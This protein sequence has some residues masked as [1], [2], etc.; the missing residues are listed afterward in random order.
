[1]KLIDRNG[2]Y[3]CNLYMH[4]HTFLC[5]KVLILPENADYLQ[6]NADMQ[7]EKLRASWYIKVYCLKL[8]MC[9]YSPTKY[10]LFSIVLTSFRQ[11]KR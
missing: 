6:K 1:M 3:I 10:Q 8:H 2:V 9:V 7:N 11:G 5:V 4:S